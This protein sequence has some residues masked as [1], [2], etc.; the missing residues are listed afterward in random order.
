MT[1]SSKIYFPH[2][3]LFRFVAA[4]MIVVVHGYEAWVSWMGNIGFLSNGTYKE[5]STWGVYVDRF[6]RN[7]GVGVD[8]FFLLS[9]FLITYL[10]LAEKERI[11][12]IHLGNFYLRRVLRIWP[13]YYLVIALTPLLI[14]INGYESPHYLPNLFFYNNFDTILT[15]QWEYPFAH[16][17]SICVEEHFYLVWP[18]LIM[19][20][21]KKYLTTLFAL[22]LVGCCA[23]RFYVFKTNP[24]AWFTLYLHTFS[25][26]DVLVVGGLVAYLHYYQK[27]KFSLNKSV[28]MILFFVLFSA[29]VFDMVGN[30]TDLFQVVYKKF[31]YTLLFALL[32]F[33][34]NLNT[35][36]RPFKWG[37][38]AFSYMGKVSFGVYMYGNLFFSII[39]GKV[40]P[41][42]GTQSLY[43]YIAILLAVTIIVPIL[44]Y[45]LYEKFFLK[46]KKKFAVVQSGA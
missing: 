33:D 4:M 42:L 9:G 20:T 17:W 43:A 41:K 28:R 10:L 23:F 46:L 25:R 29:L 14:Y 34:Y 18:I 26:I 15:Q 16:L 19:F 24:E 22:L 35:E 44:S 7:L 8:I 45:E 6:I 38:K 37:Y 12:K 13:L 2:L 11:G 36:V 30:C 40:M 39:L 27:V 21:P 31:F 32:I 5:L 1:N 3:D